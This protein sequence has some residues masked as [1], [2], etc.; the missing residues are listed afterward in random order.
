MFDN[1]GLSEFLTIA[2][3]ALLFFGPEQL[4]RM[5]AKLGSWTR[6]LITQY[7]LFTSRWS[8]EALV[9]QDAVRESRA[10]LDEI[11]AARHEITGTLQTARESV[12]ESVED[13]K[14]A[15][16]EARGEVKDR[17]QHPELE[18]GAEKS[19]AAFAETQSILDDL[20]A[21]RAAEVQE[22]AVEPPVVS[23]PSLLPDAP[24]PAVAPPPEKA[25]PL[26]PAMEPEPEAAVLQAKDEPQRAEAEKKVA[27]QEPEVA[28]SPE[29][30]EPLDD[31][32][33]N[34]SLIE[35]GLRPKA[36]KKAAEQEP[37]AAASPEEDEPL[38]D[39]ERTR[40]L[41]EEGLRPQRAK[42][43][44]ETQETIPEAASPSVEAGA[45]E[46]V[47][48]KEQL[49]VLQDQVRTL[50]RE[51]VALRAAVQKEPSGNSG[52]A[53]DAV[54]NVSLASKGIGSSLAVSD[55]GAQ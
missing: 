13:A 33:R 21:S 38:D 53:G 26:A 17:I 4:P 28:A 39:W 12:E 43:E 11:K 3:F 32:E 24:P 27:E 51:L 54:A 52:K 50:D 49:A 5:G 47:H 22:T 45:Q 34:Q 31:W 29:E 7:K 20:E 35:E 19:V 6:S 2:F 44:E 55:E 41:I 16:E 40:R 14:E 1:F 9:V 30:D 48:L 10:I 23:E 46:L 36:E 37:E 25:P 15:V 8:E 42:V 18:A